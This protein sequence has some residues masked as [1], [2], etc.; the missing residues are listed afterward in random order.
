M[1]VNKTF[2]NSSR[3][4]MSA[5]TA[6]EI[7]ASWALLL[8]TFH[9]V[10]FTYDLSIFAHHQTRWYGYGAVFHC[11]MLCVYTKGAWLENL[12]NV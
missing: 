4:V 8:H 10:K 12:N 6:F 7:C 5:G 1:H 2:V 9:V 11:F 3:F